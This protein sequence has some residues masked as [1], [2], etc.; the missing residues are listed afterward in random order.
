MTKRIRMTNVAAAVAIKSYRRMTVE[1]G[2]PA[3]SLQLKTMHTPD[4]LAFPTPPL[5]GN[6]DTGL[7]ILD[8]RFT[9]GGQSLDVGE[10]GDPWSNAAPSEKFAFRLHSFEWLKDLDA[11]ATDPK[12]NKTQPHQVAK[13]KTRAQFL[14]DRWIGI[15]GEW[16]PYSW[17]EDILSNRLF[18]LLSY[19]KNLFYEGEDTDQQSTRKRN[20][21][22]QLKRLKKTYNRTPEGISKLKAA[23]TMVLGGACLTGRTDVYLDKGL[24][25]VEDE[26]DKQILADGGHVSRSPLRCVEALEILLT[27]ESALVKREI[28]GSKQI[29]RAIDRLSPMIRFFSLPEHGFFSFN[30]SGEFSAKRLDN[31]LRQVSVG[32]KR[33]GYAPHTG[34]QRLERNGTVIMADSGSSPERPYDLEAHLA[35]LA[36]EMATEAGRL[37]VNCGWNDNQPSQ[38]REPMRATAA[39]STLVLGNKNAGKLLSGGLAEQVMGPAIQFPAGPTRSSRKEQDVGTWL[40]ASHEGY[41]A[42][43]GLIHRRRLYLDATGEDF[44]GEDSLLVPLGEAPLTSDLIPFAIRFHL[45]PRT[46]VTLAQDQNSAL[47]IQP[48]GQG[49]RFRTDGGPLKLEK[50][51][52]LARGHRPIRTEQ[53]VILGQ[54]YGDGDGQARTNRVRWTLKKM[55]KVDQN[56]TQRKSTSR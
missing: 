35:P 40:E 36:F 9:F 46:R 16:N 18:E 1:M 24:D 15:F 28:Q 12:L 41:L 27:I 31:L 30:G 17:D 44:R 34:Y 32:S 52:Y 45:A 53:L 13:A 11:V 56:I 19:W 3:R 5:S 14:F 22:R 20:L 23:A 43:F 33:F 42:D 10:N 4:F 39:H 54:A 2:A 25:L 51:V 49:W 8:G 7:Q 6:V 37:I 21:F 38:W 29:Q 48:G 50:S 26:I 47:L 55:G